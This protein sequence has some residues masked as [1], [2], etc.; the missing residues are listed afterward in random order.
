MEQLTPIQEIV[1]SEWCRN[2]CQTQDLIIKSYTGSGKTLAFLLPLVSQL[3]SENVRQDSCLKALILCPSRELAAQTERVL[4][5]LL[6]YEPSLRFSLLTGGGMGLVAGAE[7]GAAGASCAN[8]FPSPR[9]HDQSATSPALV[10]SP[11]DD[12]KARQESEQT[13]FLGSRK[14]SPQEEVRRLQADRPHVLIATPG[15]LAS[16]LQSVPGFHR[17]LKSVET[18]ICCNK[19]KR[20]SW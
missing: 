11:P 19:V 2:P 17:A 18:L 8:H 13:A 16:H 20:L 15:K 5:N 1:W 14:L 6:M 7:G 10:S 3:L 4:Q 9:P 12:S